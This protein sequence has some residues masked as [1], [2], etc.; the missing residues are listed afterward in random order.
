M[1]PCSNL[2]I[3]GTIRSAAAA[4]RSDD[5]WKDSGVQEMLTNALRIAEHGDCSGAV[6][7]AMGVLAFLQGARPY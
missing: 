4:A 7:S 3:V 2:H 1:G 5:D 6:T